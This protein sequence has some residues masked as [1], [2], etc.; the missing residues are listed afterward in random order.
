MYDIDFAESVFMGD[1]DGKITGD[2]ESEAEG[3]QIGHADLK[4]SQLVNVM[5]TCCEGYLM[6]DEKKKRCLDLLGA[7]HCTLHGLLMHVFLHMGLC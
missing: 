6:A 3:R 4:K 7:L 1:V 2:G 5:W